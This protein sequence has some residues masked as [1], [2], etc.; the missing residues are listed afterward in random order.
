MKRWVYAEVDGGEMVHL[1]IERCVGDSF[2]KVW[3]IRQGTDFEIL[4]LFRAW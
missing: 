1:E 4:S 3:K 2:I